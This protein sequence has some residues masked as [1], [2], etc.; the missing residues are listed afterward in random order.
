MSH[1]ELEGV[2]SVYGNKWEVYKNVTKEQRHSLAEGKQ[3]PSSMLKGLHNI[4]IHPQF[5]YIERLC[6]TKNAN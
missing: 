2:A 4:E 6:P 5:F 3:V 1:T